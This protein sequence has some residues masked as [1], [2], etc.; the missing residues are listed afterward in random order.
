MPRTPMSGSVDTASKVCSAENLQLSMISPR[1]G[2]NIALHAPPEARNSVFVICT[3][4]SYP[5]PPPPPS[6]QSSSKIKWRALW[7]STPACSGDLTNCGSPQSLGNSRGCSPIFETNCNR[8]WMRCKL[9]KSEY[10]W[11]FSFYASSSFSFFSV[12]FVVVIAVVKWIFLFWF[13][14]SS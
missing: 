5:L 2:Q 6:L 7:S 13:W 4:L 3:S 1:R 14:V 10:C 12:L 11:L 8:V 9:C